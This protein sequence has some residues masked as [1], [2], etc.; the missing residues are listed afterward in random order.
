MKPLTAS[1]LFDLVKDCPEVFK[2]TI[3]FHI[4]NVQWFAHWIDDEDGIMSD[5]C[6]TLT[7][8]ALFTLAAECG[9]GY[10]DVTK[11]HYAFN[12]DGQIDDTG[13]DSGPLPA[14]VAA[15]KKGRA[16]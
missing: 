7:L 14:A 8:F 6:A 11:R 3:R 12:A 13:T 4:E 5:K 15:Y 9:V 1:E 2:D 16:K 10:N